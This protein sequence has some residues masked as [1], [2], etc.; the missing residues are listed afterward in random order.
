MKTLL[1][2]DVQENLIARNLYNKDLFIQSI[3]NAIEQCRAKKYPVLFIQHNNKFLIS[4]ES[5]WQI[6][7]KLN[8]Q[9]GDWIIQKTHANAFQ[10]KEFLRLCDQNNLNEFII[11]GLVSH[12]C[13]KSTCLGGIKN[14]YT[15]RLLKNGHTCWA[16][17]AQ[18]KII[19]VE[20]ELH[21][22]KVDIIECIE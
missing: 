13:I 21:K 15:I 7:S 4:G 2:V 11:C 22:E 12:G 17:D 8:K 9:E 16:K 3:N 18:Q 14:G 5:G 20:K 6:Y 10:E 19:T 1:I